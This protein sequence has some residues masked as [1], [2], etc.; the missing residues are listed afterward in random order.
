MQWFILFLNSPSREQFGTKVTIL[1]MG[2][3][4]GDTFQMDTVILGEF[5]Q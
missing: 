4:Y 3:T 5:L 1:S 2:V